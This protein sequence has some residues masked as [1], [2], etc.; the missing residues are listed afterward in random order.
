MNK[1][2]RFGVPSER[3]VPRSLHETRQNE[4]FGLAFPWNE[5]T[6]LHFYYP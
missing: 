2:G 5:N 3:I 1:E 4:S 6:F